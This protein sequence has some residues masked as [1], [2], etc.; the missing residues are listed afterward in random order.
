MNEIIR[1]F[2]DIIMNT[3]LPAIIGERLSP[4]E[5]GLFAL[6]IQESGLGIKE[7]SVKAPREYE[8][9]KKATRPLV[10]AMIKQ[11]D[12]TPGKGEQQILINEAKLE[13]ARELQE[14]LKQIKEALPVSTRQINKP[15]CR[16]IQLA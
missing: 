4:Q 2:D 16:R 8:I 12:T 5:K 9:S 13:K 15:K 3:V 7:L 10:T 6:P 11:S 14:R 1:P